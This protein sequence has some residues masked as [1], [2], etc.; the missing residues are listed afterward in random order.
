[1]ILNLRKY[2]IIKIEIF[3]LLF[4]YKSSVLIIY[5][6]VIVKVLFHFL[7][8]NSFNIPRTARAISC[9]PS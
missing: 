9:R 3:C 1:M 2:L 4:I 8:F 7:S 5:V 6:S